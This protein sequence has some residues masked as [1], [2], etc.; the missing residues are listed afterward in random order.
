MLEAYEARSGALTATGKIAEALQDLN[1][2]IQQRPTWES[3]YNN[4][5]LIYLNTQRYADALSDFSQAIH[6][7]PAFGPAYYNRALVY[8][9]LGELG[10]A[11]ADLQTCL[12]LEPYCSEAIGLTVQRELDALR[13]TQNK[14]RTPAVQRPEPSQ[15]ST[16]AKT[17]PVSPFSQIQRWFQ[18]R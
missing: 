14:Q 3:S 15:P 17:K 12:T 1:F 4:R 16:N 8:T 11:I 6:L 9:R 10:K 7:N 18:Q 13:N 5:G 2:V